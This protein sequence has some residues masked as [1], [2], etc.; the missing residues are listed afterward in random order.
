MTS[1]G[2]GV[3]F[4]RESIGITI[5]QSG[6][7]QGWVWLQVADC[8]CQG[9]PL[10]GRKNVHDAGGS[11]FEHHFSLMENKKNYN[12]QIYYS[13]RRRKR[14]GKRVGLLIENFFFRRTKT[15]A[16][17]F[18]IFRFIE[19]WLSP[20]LEPRKKNKSHQREVGPKHDRIMN[21]KKGKSFE[22]I[23]SR[24]VLSKVLVLWGGPMG[25]L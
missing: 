4:H 21:K 8:L 18:N 5:R 2:C 12:M 6:L 20:L 13:Y 9:R 7:L 3:A 17:I 23:Q 19:I 22:I 25:E 10:R 24:F 11:F 15:T 16:Q 14:T 1:P